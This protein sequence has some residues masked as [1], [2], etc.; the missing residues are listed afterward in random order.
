MWFKTFSIWPQFY[1]RALQGVPRTTCVGFCPDKYVSTWYTQ[2][3]FCRF[4]LPRV[5]SISRVIKANRMHPTTIWSITPKGLDTFLNEILDLIFSKCVKFKKKAQFW[6]GRGAAVSTN[7]LGSNMVAGWGL[8]VWTL[9][10]ISLFLCMHVF[11]V[12]TMQE[13]GMKSGS[14]SL[15]TF[16]MQDSYRKC[17]WT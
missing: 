16:K 4:N 3:C 11:T 13:I 17:Q 12:K 5:D 10:I 15:L 7:V 2:L 8:F 1:H 14:I 6:E 9:H